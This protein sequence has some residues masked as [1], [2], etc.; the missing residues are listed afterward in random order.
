MF[1]SGSRPGKYF[2][3]RE[4]AGTLIFEW[5]MLVSDLVWAM[6]RWPRCCVLHR[7][8]NFFIAECICSKDLCA[9]CKIIDSATEKNLKKSLKG[10]LPLCNATYLQISYL[11][12]SLVEYFTLSF[13][14]YTNP[15]M[16]EFF[17][18][19]SLHLLQSYKNSNVYYTQL[20]RRG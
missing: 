10:V 1:V 6:L 2:F 12:T 17:L 7:Q 20:V 3:Q 4:P 9:Y 19:F 15:K 8:I 16:L 11:N 18:S 13:Y 5:A 14:V